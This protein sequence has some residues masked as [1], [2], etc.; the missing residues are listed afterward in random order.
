MII[1][2]NCKLKSI[3]EGFCE[4]IFLCFNNWISSKNEREIK[5]LKLLFNIK[6]KTENENINSDIPS[7]SIVLSKETRNIFSSK[8]HKKIG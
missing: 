1:Q 8:S 2:T 5:H 6:K 4:S 7:N 3:N